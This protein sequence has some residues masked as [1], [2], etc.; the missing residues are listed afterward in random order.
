[1]ISHFMSLKLLERALEATPT[2]CKETKRWSDD[3]DNA[4]HWPQMKI[5][6]HHLHFIGKRDVREC[7]EIFIKDVLLEVESIIKSEDDRRSLIARTL[8][9]P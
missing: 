5:F 3:W 7:P 4:P 8:S 2:T 1:M 9:E 6:P